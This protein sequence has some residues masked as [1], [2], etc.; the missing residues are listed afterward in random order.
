MGKRAQISKW[1]LSQMDWKRIGYK[2]TSIA[3]APIAV[4]KVKG[5]F[6]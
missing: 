5:E 3:V 1:M 4:V 2:M 6:V